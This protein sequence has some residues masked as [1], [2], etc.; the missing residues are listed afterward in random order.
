[1]KI[2]S[3]DA[4]LISYKQLNNRTGALRLFLMVRSSTSWGATAK[5][6][7]TQVAVISADILVSTRIVNCF[8]FYGRYAVAWLVEALCHRLE[9]RGVRFLMTPMDFQLTWSF[10]SQYGPWVDS[11]SNRNDY[12]IFWG[13]GYR[14]VR[15]RNSLPSVRRL[16]RKLGILDVSQFYRSPLPVAG[17]A[18]HSNYQFSHRFTVVSYLFLTASKHKKNLIPRNWSDLVRRHISL[19]RQ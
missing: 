11:A 1:M 12:Q 4:F 13:N 10:Q 2:V 8:Q 19:F 14:R 17:L 18:S 15:P 16:S 5:N 7:N 9:D 6:H 3:K